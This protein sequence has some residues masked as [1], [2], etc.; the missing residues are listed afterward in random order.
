MAIGWN[1]SAANSQLNVYR[2]TTYTGVTAYMKLHTGDPG[3]AGTANASGLTTR[4]AVT[5][6][7]ASGGSMTLS[8]IGTYTM[9][10]TET[11]TNVSFWDNP[12]AGNFLWSGTLAV[13][14]PV[15]SGT[16]LN[17]T[18]ITVSLTPIAA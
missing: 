5:W 3:A 14:A 8:S 10:T 17:F 1:A 2:G 12:T 9:N 16:I 4:N 15:V 18:A 13:S 6:N 7:A 11:I